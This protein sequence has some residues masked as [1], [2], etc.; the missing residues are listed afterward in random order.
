MIRGGDAVAD[1]I[2]LLSGYHSGALVKVA[3]A[4]LAGRQLEQAGA[5]PASTTAIFRFSF[6]LAPTDFS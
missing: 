4:E 5:L 2:V 1:W 3:E 6:A